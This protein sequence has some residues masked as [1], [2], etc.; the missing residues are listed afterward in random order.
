M[1]A[2]AFQSVPYVHLHVTL[3]TTTSPF[4]N[5]TYFAGDSKPP[6]SILTSFEGARNGLKGPPFNSISYHGRVAEG[7]DEWVVKIFS[8]SKLTKKWLRKVFNNQVGWVLHKEVRAATSLPLGHIFSSLLLQ[9]DAYPGE[10]SPSLVFSLSLNMLPVPS[11]CT[12]LGVSPGSIGRWP[13]LCQCLRT[14][15]HKYQL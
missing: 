10:N 6:T 13:L 11:S 14:V 3:L 9:W 1:P 15:S 8:E 12:Y 2:P 4:P 5:S 7:K